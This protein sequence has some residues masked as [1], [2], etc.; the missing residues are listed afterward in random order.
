MALKVASTAGP[1]GSCGSPWVRLAWHQG[2]GGGFLFDIVIFHFHSRHRILCASEDLEKHTNGNV[3]NAYQ[4]LL[5]ATV[6][7]L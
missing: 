4:N 5:R 6:D 7:Y 3:I 1:G 2:G